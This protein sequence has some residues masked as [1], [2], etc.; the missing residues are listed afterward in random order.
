MAAL[1]VMAHSYAIE[2]GARGGQL[3]LNVL[4]PLIAHNLLS[5]QELLGNACE[6]MRVFCI[7]GLKPDEARIENN[8]MNGLMVATA[9]APKLGYT[10]VSN[11][12]KEADRRGISIKQVILEK[13]LFSESE[14]DALLDPKKMTKPG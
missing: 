9:L 11:L 8:L 12:I 14:L 13:K 5:A 10:E 4:T 2:L 1:Q 3:Q 6:M 7:E